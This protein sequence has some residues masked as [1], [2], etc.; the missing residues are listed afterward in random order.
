MYDQYKKVVSRSMENKLVLGLSP[1]GH[2][3]SYAVGDF[4]GNVLVHSELERDIRVKQAGASSLL[5]WLSDSRSEEFA[6]R[7]CHLSLVACPVSLKVHSILQKLLR[8]SSSIIEEDLDDS[9]D[10]LLRL[11]PLLELVVDVS[12]VKKRYLA[13]LRLCPVLYIFGHHRC[14]AAE[15]WGTCG[16]NRENSLIIT[17]DGGG[18][19][20]D[21]K[22]MLKESHFSYTK[23]NSS[24]MGSTY[25][26]WIKSFGLVYLETTSYLGFS[27]GPPQGSQEGSVMG[28][29]AY[30]SALRTQSL[31]KNDYL[32]E[33][34][35]STNPNRDKVLQARQE[36][37]KK[38]NKL[39]LDKNN[40][41]ARADLAAGIQAEF[42]LRFIR[43]VVKLLKEEQLSD[44]FKATPSILFSGGCSLNCAAIGKLI[45]LL[46]SMRQGNDIEVFVSPVPYDGGLSIGAFFLV[47]NEFRGVARQ[48]AHSAFLGYSYSK[49]SIF[50]A[51]A[52]F[53]LPYQEIDKKILVE[54]LAKGKIL[55]VFNSKSESGRRALCNRSIIA[56]PR[57]K[58]IRDII[59]KKVKH[60]PLFRPFAPVILEEHVGQ[61]FEVEVKSPYMSY[62]IPFLHSKKKEVPSVVHADGTGRLQTVRQEQNEW[63]YSLLVEWNMLTNCPILIN[64]S[65]NDNEPI[66]ETPSNAIACFLRT[67]IDYLVFPELGILVSRP[68]KD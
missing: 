46:R 6:D 62:A 1:F 33:N 60:R 38:I 47:L 65:F 45:V 67:S 7:I 44:Q 29:A 58:L 40:D 14:H 9:I 64:T 51:L 66:V 13:M 54:E 61:W 68:T 55:S 20:F 63:I 56:D 57:N 37:I 31:F 34:T 32:W 12:Y 43:F 36:L 4:Q 42:E 19:D 52:G 23:V 3:C 21:N 15:A 8:N 27:V 59:N 24:S 2:D 5:Y 22:N 50:N 25:F 11:S 41:A 30:G 10:Y 48:Q 39:V 35:A 18:W 16:R 28:L 17:F 49:M 26:N 53:K